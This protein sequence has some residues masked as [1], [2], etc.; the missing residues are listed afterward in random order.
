MKHRL[1]AALAFLLAGSLALQATEITGR[2]QLPKPPTPPV[3][4]QRYE[5]VA[6]GGVVAMSPPLAVVYLEGDFPA[7][8]PAPTVQL[9]QKGLAFL[10]ALLPIQVGTRVEFPNLDDVYHNVFSFSPPKR[11]DLGR[12]Q[13]TDRPIPSQVFDKPGLVTLRCEIHHHM[14][15]LILVLNSPHFTVTDETG[16]F[17][18]TGLPAG[19]FTLKAWID[20]ATSRTQAVELTPGATVRVDFP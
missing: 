10:P 19:R 16:H 9:V 2:V 15:G 1:L 14:R 20:S 6:S 17:R 5:V 18:L 12:Y 8:A 4:T 11:F 13:P 7:P 3:N